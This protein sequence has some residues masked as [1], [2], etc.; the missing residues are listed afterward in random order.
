[1]TRCDSR[2]GCDSTRP[3]N[4]LRCCCS[5][6][7]A[8]VSFVMERDKSLEVLA[9]MLRARSCSYLFGMGGCVRVR[10]VMRGMQMHCRH[11]MLK[12]FPFSL[13]C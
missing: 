3:F 2:V 1:M 11:L 10:C 12:P 6:V 4:L 13:G 9:A 8:V 5:C 7:G